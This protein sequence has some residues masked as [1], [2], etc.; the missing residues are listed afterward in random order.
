MA[1]LVTDPCLE[2]RLRTEREASGADRYDEVWEGVYMMA[3][4]PTDEHQKIVSRLGHVV[5]DVLGDAELAEIRPG[6][7][8]SD[9]ERRL[10]VRLSRAGRGWCDAAQAHN[11]GLAESCEAGAGDHTD[12]G[13][14]GHPAVQDR[15]DPP[16]CYSYS[17]PG[18]GG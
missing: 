17:T 8:L 7:N 15:S 5:E 11:D 9:R 12:G 13:G 18:R 14:W 4:M 10:E 1:I 2:E 16:A 3:P 6:V